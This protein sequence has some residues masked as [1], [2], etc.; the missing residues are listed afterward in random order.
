M[1]PVIKISAEEKAE[2]WLFKVE[3]NGI[4]LDMKF[5]DKVFEIFNRLH[6]GDKY[7]G[8]GI[9]LAICKR[10]VERHK[11]EIWID[12]APG[13]GTIFYFTLPAEA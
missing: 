2:G 4:G 11:G 1:P 8:S 13:Y 9:G 5:K 6:S 3:D 10:I 12:S 7:Q